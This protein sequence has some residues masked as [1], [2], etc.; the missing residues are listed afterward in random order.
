MT[1]HK[2]K[3]FNTRIPAP[4]VQCWPRE[5]KKALLLVFP[6]IYD[7]KFEFKLSHVLLMAICLCLVGVYNAISELAEERR[8]AT[9]NGTRERGGAQS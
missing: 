5:L 6:E 8:R 1:R 3:W 7:K 4:W 9:S 2:T